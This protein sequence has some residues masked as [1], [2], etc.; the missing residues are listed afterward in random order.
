MDDAWADAKEKYQASPRVWNDASDRIAADQKFWESLRA[1]QPMPR[2]K[3][4]PRT[5]VDCIADILK[6]HERDTD[7]NIR[8]LYSL[9]GK[10]AESLG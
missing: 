3:A 7:S 6:K 1:C 10:I 5:G 8:E 9:A 2:V 4:A